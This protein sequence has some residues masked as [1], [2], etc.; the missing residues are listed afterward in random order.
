MVS[1]RSID[2][3]LTVIQRELVDAVVVDVRKFG[4]TGALEIVE[5]FPGIPVFA[6]SPFRPD[7]GRLIEECREGGMRGILVQGVDDAVIG[8]VLM[9]NSASS[10]CRE[11]LATAPRLLRLTESLQLRAWNEVLERV[12]KPTT[13]SDIA[14]SIGHTREYISREFGAGGAPNLKRVIDLVRAA[15]AADLLKNP[16]YTVRTVSEILQFSSPSHLT[17][18]AR[19]V[20]GVASTEL[21]DLGPLGVLHRFRRGRTR[22]RL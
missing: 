22:S 8:E 15:W 3:V 9:T 5:N 19:R 7:D 14:R 20:A 2:R 1:C 4:T 11:A 10:L 18:C 17:G 16:G 13:T 12:G 6:L 21:A